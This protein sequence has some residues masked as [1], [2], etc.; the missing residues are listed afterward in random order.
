MPEMN[1]ETYNKLKGVVN[2]ISLRSNR[3]REWI[4]LESRLL[5]LETSFN[6]FYE[7]V[8]SIS[9]IPSKTRMVQLRKAWNIFK[10]T[11]VEDLKSFSLSVQ[12]IKTT[13][14][15]SDGTQPKPL[16]DAWIQELLGF[17]DQIQTDLLPDTMAINSLKSHSTLFQQALYARIAD[18]RNL[19]RGEILELC[20]LTHSLSNRLD[21]NI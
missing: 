9:G 20:L 17:S 10:I 12:F 8:E 3:I 1:A 7:K 13:L 15:S 18:R 14:P 6:D 5:N 16:V 11:D 21:E 19:M 4:E 2:E